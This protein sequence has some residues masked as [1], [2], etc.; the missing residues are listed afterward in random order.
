M[1]S[2]NEVL[3][4]LFVFGPTWDGD[5]VSKHERTELVVSGLADQWDGWNFLTVAGVKMAVGC[6]LKARDWHDKRYY[7]KA[8]NLA[9]VD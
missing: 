9:P 2:K 5:L 7:R 8:A 4:Q 6:G 1:F 3:M